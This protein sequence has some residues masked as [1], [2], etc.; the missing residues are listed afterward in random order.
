MRTMHFL[1]RLN[2]TFDQRRGVFLAQT[3]IPP[4]EEAIAIMMQEESHKRLHSEASG[5]RGMRS[6][7]AASNSCITGSRGRLTS[8]TTATKW[9]ILVRFVLDH[10]RRERRVDVDNLE[11][12]VV[13]VKVVKVVRLGLSGKSNGSR[14][15]G[16]DRPGLY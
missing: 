9:G 14:G 10:L 15:R 7:L 4:L 5:L 2:P 8:V 16:R 3:K 12:V 6:A 11:V 13:A 1:S